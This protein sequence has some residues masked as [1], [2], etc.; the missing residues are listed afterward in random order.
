MECAYDSQGRR[1][2]KKVVLEHE[3]MHF[4]IYSRNWSLAAREL[5][6]LE[7]LYCSWQWG[8][9]YDG[10]IKADLA[11][12]YGGK[13]IL[14]YMNPQLLENTDYDIRDYGNQNSDRNLIENREQFAAEV[15]RLGSEIAILKE[16]L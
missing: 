5:N 4:S 13:V 16:K 6:Q 8:G 3:M 15:E 7:K 1:F 2:E 14:Y 10:E 12:K 11:V 9:I